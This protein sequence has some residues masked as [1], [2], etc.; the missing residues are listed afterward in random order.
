M[1]PI[2]DNNPTNTVPVVTIILIVLNSLIWLYEIS[3]GSRSDY[4][5]LG[6]GLTPWRF[7][8]YYMYQG[9]FWAN[10]I[11]PLFWSI[12]MHAGWL[13]L[14]GNMWFLWIFGDNIEERLGHINYLIF[15]LLCGIGA[16]LIHVAFN[17]LSKDSDCW[18]ERRNKRDSRRLPDMLSKCS[19]LYSFD[20]F[21]YYS[22]C[23]NS[24]ILISDFLVGFSVLGR[25]SPNRCRGEC[26]WR[27]ILGSHGRIRHRGGAPMAH[28]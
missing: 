3:L 10:S 5:I 15:Y 2:R 13:H 26:R 24:C 23:R 7:T 19:H 11:T 1:I 27:S 18:S 9:G 28:G 8:H 12:F 6:Y 21:R 20:N 17:P 25:S 4:F 22:I 16:S 14:I